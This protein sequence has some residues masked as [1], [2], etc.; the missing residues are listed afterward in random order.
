MQS[1]DK[2]LG[3]VT[4]RLNLDRRLKEHTLAGF[5]P[6]LVSPL[7]AARSRPLYFDSEGILVV[8]V[9]D[10]ATSQELGMSKHKLL[11]QLGKAAKS[12]GIEVKGL[13]MDLKQ[14]ASV[15]KVLPE[16]AKA[17]PA[18][19]EAS[20]EAIAAI[21]L[22]TEELAQLASLQA[23]LEQESH[24]Q[25]VKDRILKLF[26]RELRFARWRRQM[27][28]PACQSCGIRAQRMQAK[29]AGDSVYHLCLACL[30]M[31]SK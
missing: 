11:A 4:A 16:G 21:S 24:A 10:A 15:T 3:S 18:D 28:F 22:G 8:A 12:L 29:K 17:P 30:A 23:D 20:P 27:D 13:R 25:E 1:C 31:S 5:W 19:A 2:I 26:E 14:W 7:L 6:D 9:A